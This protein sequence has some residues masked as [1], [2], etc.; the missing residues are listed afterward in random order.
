MFAFPRGGSQRSN[1]LNHMQKPEPAYP[2]CTGFMNSSRM[3]AFMLD[4]DFSSWQRWHL[5]CLVDIKNL[6]GFPCCFRQKSYYTTVHYSS[7]QEKSPVC[8]TL[9]RPRFL[10]EFL[11]EIQLSID[12]L[13]LVCNHET[14]FSISSICI[15]LVCVV[16]TFL[17]GLKTKKPETFPKDLKTFEI[18]IIK[19]KHTETFRPVCFVQT[20][21]LRHFTYL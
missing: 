20:K 7:L 19:V 14:S 8:Q 9:T 3:G 15:E 16:D 5:L 10:S 21:P 1:T 17:Y 6:H 18:I 2:Y 4:R 12:L 13:R 11:R